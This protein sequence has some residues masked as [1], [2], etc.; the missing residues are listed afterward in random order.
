MG[1]LVLEL[2]QDAINHNEK[3]TTLLRKALVVATKLNFPE[4]RKWIEQELEGYDGKSQ[5]IPN[6]RIVRGELRASHPH[7][8]WIPYLFD[9]PK[10]AETLSKRRAQQPIG[11]LEHLLE[12]KGTKGILTMPFSPEMLKQLD[13]GNLELGIIPTLIVDSASIQGIIDAVRNVVLQWSLKLESDG[14]VGEGLTFSKEEKEKASSVAYHIQNFTDVAGTVTTGNLQI[15]NYCTIHQDLKARG[16]SQQ[17]RN[18]LEDI[19][20]KLENSQGQDKASAIKSGTEWVL[21]HSKE[22]GDLAKVILSWF[23]G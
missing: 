10:S 14:I 21:A 13:T 8:Q 9:D 11:E 12:K 15:G 20:D 22:L 18:E 16:I 2:Q 5:N 7:Y 19:L 23:G 1:S 3:V 4:F 17:D 6:Y